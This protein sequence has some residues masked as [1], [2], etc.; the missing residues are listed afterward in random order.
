MWIGLF[1]VFCIVI[2]DELYMMYD[3]MASADENKTS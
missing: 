3:Y 1:L 2:Y